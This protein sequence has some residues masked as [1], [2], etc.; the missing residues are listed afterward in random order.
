VTKQFPEDTSS[1]TERLTLTPLTV[2]DADEMVKVL[3]D[4]RLHEFIGGHPASLGELHERYRL[5]LAGALEPSE[6]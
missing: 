2:D 5:F 6:M 3:D 1:V 4:A